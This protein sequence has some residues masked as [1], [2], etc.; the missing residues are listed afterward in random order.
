MFVYR[1]WIL[2]TEYMHCVAQGDFVKAGYTDKVSGHIQN[3]FVYRTWILETEYMHCVAEGDDVK[4]GYT[5]K[6]NGH[7]W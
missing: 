1:T 7:I 5:D 3:M 2:E 6:G 4:A